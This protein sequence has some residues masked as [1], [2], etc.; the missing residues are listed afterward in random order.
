VAA[1]QRRLRAD[2]HR[3]G[4]A[5]GS[6]RALVALPQACC[7]GRSRAAGVPGVAAS[8]L[9]RAGHRDLTVL[10]GGAHDWAEVTG[11]ELETGP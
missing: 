1:A 7:L 4:V 3:E 5:P 6:S 10:A 11:R 8:L 9:E 2:P